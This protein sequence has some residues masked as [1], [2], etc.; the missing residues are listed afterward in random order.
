[1]ERAGIKDTT[2]YKITRQMMD[3]IYGEDEKISSDEF[4]VIFNIYMNRGGTWE[5]IMAGDMKNA[6]ILE[7]ILEAFI[8]YRSIFNTTNCR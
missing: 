7:D 6:K 8:N 5:G 2:A 4:V 3:H 1:V